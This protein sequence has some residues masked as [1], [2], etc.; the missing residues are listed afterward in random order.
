MVVMTEAEIP[1]LRGEK[2]NAT[3]TWLQQVHE[4]LMRIRVQPDVPRPPYQPGQYTTLA[5][6]NWEPRAPGCQEENLSAEALTK[7]TRRAYSISCPILN[8]AGELLDVDRSPWMEFYIVLMRESEKDPV[9]AL[10]PRL[11]MVKEGDRVHLGE[12]V[13]GSYKLRPMGPDDTV[14]LLSTGTGEA[15]HNYMIWQLLHRGHRGR[16]LSAC[17]VR[18]RRDCAYLPVHEEL[19]R[20]YPNYTYLPLTTRE[21]VPGGQKVYI[22]DLIGS[23]KLEERLGQPLDP[24]HTQVYLCGNPAMIGIPRKDP[25][26]GRL[27]YP[28]PLGAVEV[29][30]RRGFHADAAGEKHT[31]I[32]HNIHFEKYW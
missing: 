11:F 6:G 16:I 19:M 17:C 21:L 23:G 13:V 18:Y 24:R 22:Q 4:D 14:L 31:S 1:R 15:P 5:L 9:P 2:Y 25:Q 27:T 20:R 30:E 12:K 8:D 32:P 3:V 10:T 29:L 26:T 7:L 28:Q